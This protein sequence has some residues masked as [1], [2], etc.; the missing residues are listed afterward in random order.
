[1][2]NH[3]A[4][5]TSALYGVVALMAG[6]AYWILARTIAAAEGEASLLAKTI[7]KDRKG[8]ASVL[9]Y[10]IAIPLAFVSQWI[11]LAIYVCVAMM[12]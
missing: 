12:W 6:I 7:G 2:E 10:R 1:M 5:L 9:L 11:A 4:R 8:T 3:S